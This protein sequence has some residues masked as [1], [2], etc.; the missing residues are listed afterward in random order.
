MTHLSRQELP[1][2]AIFG[3][4]EGAKNQDQK[5]AAFG[6]SYGGRPIAY[7]LW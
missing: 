7:D 2:A 3:V 1:K 4:C 5:I 6:S